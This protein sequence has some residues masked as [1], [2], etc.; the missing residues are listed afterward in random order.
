MAAFVQSWLAPVSFGYLCTPVCHS[1]HYSLLPQQ[2]KP[3]AFY[4]HI[5][6]FSFTLDPIYSMSQ[7][8]VW[9][10]NSWMR[11][12]C[13]LWLL[14]DRLKHCPEREGWVLLESASPVLA[15]SCSSIDVLKD[16]AWAKLSDLV[17]ST[18]YFSEG[19]EPHPAADTKLQGSVGTPSWGPPACPLIASE[20]ATSPFMNKV[21]LVWHLLTLLERDGLW[22]SSIISSSVG[23]THGQQRKAIRNP[24]R[25]LGD[26]GS[27]W[28][29]G[30]R[31]TIT[32]AI[33]WL[34]PPPGAYLPVRGKSPPQ[35]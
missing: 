34:P 4:H 32:G 35:S 24:E 5:C 29:G 13:F 26:G 15:P 20:G 17:L 8:G 14:L 3:A 19:A 1:P 18:G 33:V 27:P 11:S 10:C 30:E 12:Q 6:S 28:A 21:S 9:A 2:W 7:E 31:D 25:N 22:V 23:V 16:E